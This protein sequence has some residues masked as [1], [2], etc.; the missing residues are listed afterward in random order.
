MYLSIC[1]LVL[2]PVLCHLLLISIV[3]SIYTFLSCVPSMFHLIPFGISIIYSYHLRIPIMSLSIHILSIFLS[4]SIYSFMYDNLMFTSYY[5]IFICAYYSC[6]LDY[7]I[8]CHI[9][10]YLII[11]YYLYLSYIMT[12]PYTF[13]YLYI[14]KPMYSCSSMNLLYLEIGII[15]IGLSKLK[16]WHF[17]AKLVN[18]PILHLGQ[19]VI[20][21]FQYLDSIFDTFSLY[22]FKAKVQRVLLQLE[23]PKSEYR[24]SSY[25]LNNSN[26][27]MIKLMQELACT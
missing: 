6:T 4:C 9:L 20:L 1:V 3:L 7:H 23:S 24:N 5:L 2:I 12:Y 16:L 8:L 17:H 13:L 15:P 11:S 19:F 10:S 27:S 18:L 25:V 14:M 22:S 21:I 26:Y